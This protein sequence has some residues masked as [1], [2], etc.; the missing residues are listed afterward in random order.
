MAL[1]QNMLT[2]RVEKDRVALAAIE[3]Y[4]AERDTDEL[5]RDLPAPLVGDAR[6]VADKLGADRR[7]FNELVHGFNAALSQAVGERDELSAKA[8]HLKI[9][10][11]MLALSCSLLAIA[12][13]LVFATSQ[14]ARGNLAT[15]WS[16]AVGFFR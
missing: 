3:H 14:E 7:E 4:L 11:N 5:R 16:V 13:A 9:L 6:K 1:H 8:G 15:C 10:R 2:N 12:L